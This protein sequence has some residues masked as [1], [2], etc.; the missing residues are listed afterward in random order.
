M[1]RW[2]S[3]PPN[4]R[5]QTDASW[6]GEEDFHSTRAWFLTMAVRGR[7]Y[8]RREDR[9]PGRAHGYHRGDCDQPGRG[10]PRDRE[11]RRDG[12][13]L[14]CGNRHSAADIHGT[15]RFSRVRVVLARWQ[16]TP[17]LRARR[18]PDA[19]RYRCAI[20]GR[21]GLPGSRSRRLARDLGAHRG[22]T[23]P[24]FLPLTDAAPYLHYDVTYRAGAGL[25]D[26][27]RITTHD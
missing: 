6:G 8:G 4:G 7:A 14:G 3:T 25:A 22:A 10:S 5:I 15:H 2:S 24:G 20:S 13:P 1:T 9:I 16:T 26:Q 17:H 19:P 27:K 21:P 18:C 11:L 23:L 12:R